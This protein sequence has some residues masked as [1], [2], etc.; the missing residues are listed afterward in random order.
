MFR[1]PLIVLGAMAA[2]CAYQAEVR[3][4]CGPRR[5]HQPGS[6]QLEGACEVL[7]TQRFG[8][9]GYCSLGHGS[10]AQDGRGGDRSEADVSVDAGMC[11]GV[12]GGQRR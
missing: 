12:W 2:G 10:E 1:L 5:I 8:E 6:N 7:V 3:V 11:G 9:H 4:G